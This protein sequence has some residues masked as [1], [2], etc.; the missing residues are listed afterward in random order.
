MHSVVRVQQDQV[1][2][3]E[4]GEDTSAGEVRGTH[5]HA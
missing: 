2:D 4:D 3:V 1:E 5:D